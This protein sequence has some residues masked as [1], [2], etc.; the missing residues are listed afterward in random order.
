L[1]QDLIARLAWNSGTCY[2]AQ[3]G[4]KLTILLPPS[5]ECWDYRWIPQHLAIGINVR[6]NFIRSFVLKIREVMVK[7]FQDRYRM[8]S[9]KAD[10]TQ[11]TGSM[12]EDVGME[13]D[14]HSKAHPS[15][16]HTHTH[17]HTLVHTL[18]CSA[19]F[20]LLFAVVK[21]QKTGTSGSYLEP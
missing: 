16:T 5:P 9:W 4:L 14:R 19:L 17:I 13:G 21:I 12:H 6:G 2:A 1:R 11:V 10:Q 20:L 7:S 3:T 18:M 15:Q 8:R